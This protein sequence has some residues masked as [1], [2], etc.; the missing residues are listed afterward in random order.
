MT[1]KTIADRP[2][3][4]ALVEDLLNPSR[5]R[6]IVLI[7]TA[8]DGSGPRL[9]VARVQEHVAELADIAVIETGRISM[10]LEDSLTP[11]AQ[12]YGGA[13]RVYPVGTAWLKDLWRSPLR[14]AVTAE[15][16]AKMTERIIDDVISM[17]LRQKAADGAV[18]SVAPVTGAIPTPAVLAGAGKS[19]PALVAAP[20]A[21][22]AAQTPV[23]ARP[24]GK[25]LRDT[26]A[27]LLAAQGR[28]A[29]LEAAASRPTIPV[30]AFTDV[31]DAVDHAIYNRWVQVVPATEKS[32]TGMAEYGVSPA[33]SDSVLAVP[34]AQ[35]RDV[36]TTV[37]NILTGDING[38][39]AGDRVV[40]ATAAGTVSFRTHPNG[41]L[42]LIE[43]A[44]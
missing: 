23:P 29:E 40:V 27:A 28:I 18:T 39:P 25:A 42:E 5:A 16:G 26:Q 33:F 12:V 44:R 30:D 17:T 24:T 31:D 11:G 7:S 32:E 1:W 13:A 8:A 22:V 9:N 14:I 2:A 19:T 6:P 36:L 43:V 15:D 34:A 3:V 41:L 20:V 21:P 10:L 35:L 4:A 38:E 37:V